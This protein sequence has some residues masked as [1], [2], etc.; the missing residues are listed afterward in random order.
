MNTVKGNI[1]LN[2]RGGSSNFDYGVVVDNNDPTGARR[3]KVRINVIDDGVS[4]EDLMWV[5]PMIPKLVNI[6]P[7]KNE[8]VIIFYK[9]NNDTRND[10]F[11]I[12]PIISQ[13]QY[14]NKS[15][16]TNALSGLSS[17][18]N[19]LKV[20]INDNPDSVGVFEDSED[21]VID[22]RDNTD[23]IFR[24]NSISIRAGKYSGV[25]D[26]NLPILN[27]KNPTY[28]QLNHNVSLYNSNITFSAINIVSDKINLLTHENG[29]PY[30]N[31]SDKD[32][33]ISDEDMLKILQTAH[34][35]AFGDVLLNYLLLM[36]EVL[37]NHVHPYP[38]LTAVNMNGDDSIKKLLDFD[39]T[40]ILSKNIKIN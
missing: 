39:I 11:Y 34:P 36:R 13:H 20:N 30:F 1:N 38:G 15:D 21:L 27:T 14:I 2:Q 12:G 28:I 4:D 25:D 31:L 3:I 22:G 37:L 18:S 7:K 24:K 29:D 10:R 8:V 6:K 35:L 5:F 40:K 16:F 17:G 9:S 19:S 23:I 32:K 33:M 26:N